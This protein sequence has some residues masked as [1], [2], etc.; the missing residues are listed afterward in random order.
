MRNEGAARVAW[1]YARGAFPDMFFNPDS[2]ILNTGFFNS[3]LLISVHEKKNQYVE[4]SLPH[5]VFIY[6]LILDLPMQ[7]Y[8]SQS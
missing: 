7:G 4:N 2:G 3:Y 6:S 5:S 1:V 8:H